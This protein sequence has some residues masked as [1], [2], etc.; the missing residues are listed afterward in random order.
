MPRVTAD[1][2]VPGGMALAR[3]DEGVIFL[4]GVLP[5][6]VVDV[7]SH[8]RVGGARHARTLTVIEPSPERRAEVDCPHHPTCGGCD[9]LHF[10][11]AARL[12]GLRQ[13]AL[14]GLRRVARL[15]EEELGRVSEVRAAP[16]LGGRRRARVAVG[17]GGALGFFARG[18]EALVPIDRCPALDPVLDAVLQ[19]VAALGDLPQGARLRLAIDERGHRSAAIEGLPERGARALCQRLV[20][21]GVVDGALTLDG[22]GEQGFVCGD[23][24]LLGEIAPDD[25]GGPYGSDAATFSQASRFGGRAI[26]EAVLAGLAGKELGERHLLELFAGAGHLTFPLARQGFKV[27]AVE[28]AAHA[29][30][31]LRENLARTDDLGVRVVEGGIDGRTFGAGLAAYLEIEPDVIVADPPRTGIPR[32]HGILDLIAPSV[33]VL[34]SCDIATGARDLAIA[35]EYGYAVESV[36]L[37][38]CFERTS[39]LEWVAV[40]TEILD[41]E[42]EDDEDEEDEDE[43]AGGG[44]GDG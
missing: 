36:T 9:W 41:E 31:W 44:D 21:A 16:T 17:E 5:G 3:D 20:D 12:A 34:V 23:P 38:D 6:E 35:K 11:D 22:E 7:T 27:L 43:Q 28:G 2:L 32:L 15:S 10:S 25:E 40:L 24:V 37:L 26:T 29:A 4:P 14:D 18:S 39:H 1:Q 33:I 30:T 13:M 42:E 8:R 19:Q